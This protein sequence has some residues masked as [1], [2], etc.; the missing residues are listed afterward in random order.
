MFITYII[1]GITVIVSLYALKNPVVLHKLAMNPHQVDQK[2]EYYRLITS[3]FVH[4]DNTHLLVNMFSLYFFGIAVER[5]FNNLFGSAG[6][7]YFV[8]LYLLAILVSD[9]PSFIKNRKKTAYNS[10]GASG[11][12]AAVVFAFIIFKPLQDIC[13]FIALCMPGFILGSLY[14]V[15]SYLQGRKPN[16]KLKGINHDA[17]LYGA[18]FGLLYCIVIYPQCIPEFFE[19]V[20]NW[21]VLK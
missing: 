12:I 4:A 17:H 18:L 5:V 11:G 9:I 15:F 7:I 8:A 16:E 13:I 3:G 10:L 20:R 21:E 14:I 19:Q 1:I 2:K 6:N